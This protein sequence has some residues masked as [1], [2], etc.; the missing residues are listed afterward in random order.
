MKGLDFDIVRARKKEV[1]LDYIILGITL[2]TMVIDI[3]ICK[4]INDELV[5]CAFLMIFLIALV[6]FIEA[7]FNI[8]NYYKKNHSHELI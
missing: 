7:I 1:N 5:D 2:F 6:N 4:C 3:I 8:M